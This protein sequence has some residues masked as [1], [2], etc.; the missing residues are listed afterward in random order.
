MHQTTMPSPAIAALPC[1]HL[2]TLFLAGLLFRVSVDLL[3]RF[4]DETA[5]C[6]AKSALYEV[7]ELRR[8]S[9]GHPHPQVRYVYR[10]RECRRRG[11]T[12]ALYGRSLFVWEL[13]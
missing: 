8:P 3:T 12:A 1:N 4:V 5:S 9:C 6:T 10:R 13:S 11:M 2:Q 7:R